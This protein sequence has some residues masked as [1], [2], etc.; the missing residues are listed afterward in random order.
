LKIKKKE[1]S[2][3]KKIFKYL[4]IAAIAGTLGLNVMNVSAAEPTCPSGQVLH[5]NYYFFLDVNG[6]DAVKNSTTGKDWVRKNGTFS[7][8][9]FDSTKGT[10]K[11]MGQVKLTLGGGSDKATEWSY[12]DFWN[13]YY[14]AKEKPTDTVEISQSDGTPDSSKIY[15]DGNIK[16]ILHGTWWEVKPG[17]TEMIGTATDSFDSANWAKVKEMIENNTLASSDLITKGTDPA[18]AVVDFEPG[19]PDANNNKSL[20]WYVNRT[21]KQDSALEGVQLHD[22]LIYGPAVTYIRYCAAG[23]GAEPENPDEPENDKLL[24]YD[25]NADNVTN[26]PDSQK[27]KDSTTISDKKPVRKGYSFAGWSEDKNAS[28]PDYKPGDTY[29]GDSTTMYAIWKSFKIEY[30]ANGGKDAPA[31]QQGG[32]GECLTISSQKPTYGKHTFLGWSTNPDATEADPRFAPGKEYCGE[33]GDLKL[34]AVWNFKTGVSA[35]LVTFGIVAIAAT[36]ALIVAKKKNL[37]RQI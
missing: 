10:F 36:S 25:G 31:T 17:T 37:F 29:T 15:T 4:S 8:R 27:F 14:K 11:D 13:N 1:E 18:N 22:K 9:E 34:Y 24:Q 7:A 35:H 12:E 23:T 26:V 16:Y 2:I 30:D 6:A 33:D 20:L 19:F 28:E 32:K 21:Y 3:M 5:T